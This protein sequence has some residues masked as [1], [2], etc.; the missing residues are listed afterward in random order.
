MQYFL[1]YIKLF[2][3]VDHDL[4]LEKLAAYKFSTTSQN[5]TRSYLT[6][7]KQCTVNQNVRSSFQIVKSGVPQ[8]S[9]FGKC[10]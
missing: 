9:V 6:N 2:Y 4:L 5:W 1:I 8:G 10:I 3:V 7:I